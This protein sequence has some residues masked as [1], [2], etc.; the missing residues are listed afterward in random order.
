MVSYHLLSNVG[1]RG[2][3]EDSVGMYQNEEEFC[4]ALADGLGGHG[5]GELASSLAVE[6][7]VKMFVVN[8]AGEASLD[9]SFREAQVTILEK[10]KEGKKR[11][12]QFGNVEIP[13]QAFMS[14]LKLDEE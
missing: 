9:A 10:Q 1:D 7:V 12:R 3:N 4:F 6:S 11:M 2:N 5:K 8:G 14:V 13:Q